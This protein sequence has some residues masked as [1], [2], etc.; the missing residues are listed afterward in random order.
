MLRMH[1][2]LGSLRTS[3]D[4]C[5]NVCL[6]S[7]GICHEK[8]NLLDSGAE[9]VASNDETGGHC[10]EGEG[11]KLKLNREVGRRAFNGWDTTIS[12]KIVRITNERG[13]ET[14]IGT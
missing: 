2:H 6:D 9:T 11:I 5:N 7:N 14:L 3:D 1:R 13:P 4:D 8:T 10:E 12:V